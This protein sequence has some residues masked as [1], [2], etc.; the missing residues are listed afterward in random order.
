MTQLVLAGCR[1]SRS[2]CREKTPGASSRTLPSGLS[3]CSPSA[4][5]SS[6]E[7]MAAIP[8]RRTLS[9]VRHPLRHTAALD[10]L[11]RSQR[12]NATAGAGAGESYCAI[13]FNLSTG[14]VA[15]DRICIVFS[16][17]QFDL[18]MAQELLNES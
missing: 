12:Q 13:P 16:T 2:P 10:V 9:S 11:L 1:R 18:R 7:N 3:A 6:P 17:P 15:L 14:G 5:N 4:I 8:M